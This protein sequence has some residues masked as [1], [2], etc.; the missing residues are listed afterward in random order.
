MITVLVT[1]AA[2][3][4]GSVLCPQ[5]LD[6]GFKVIAVDSLMFNNGHAV[7]PCLG[8]KNYEFYRHNV[9]F[10][11][12]LKRLVP[13]ADVIIPLAALVGAPLCDQYP[14]EAR[15]VNYK[16]VADIIDAA[17]DKLERLPLIILTNTNSGYGQTDGTS[18]VTEED[19][20]NPISIYGQTKCDAEALVLEYERGITFRLATVFG[21]SPRPRLDLMVNDFTTKLSVIKDRRCPTDTTLEIFEPHFMRNFIHVRDVARAIIHA[22]DNCEDMVGAYNLGHPDCNMSKMQLAERICQVIGLDKKSITVGVG[23]DKDKRNYIVS[24]QKILRVGFRFENDLDKGIS[25]V[26][27]MVTSVFDFGPQLATM[28]NA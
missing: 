10:S 15:K 22:I 14:S 2:G 5:L 13:K 17:H 19:P 1:G 24:N 8:H 7:L 12:L 21:A 18:E 28:R 26:H 23:E 20:L 11:P 6:A 9:T 27:Q 16:Q 25:E 4:I 3:Y